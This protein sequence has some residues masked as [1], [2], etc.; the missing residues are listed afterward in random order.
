V[1][2]ERIWKRFFA[3]LRMTGSERLRMTAEVLFS[4]FETA[5]I[6]VIRICG[7]EFV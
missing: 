7:F 5:D 3:P 1:G 2:E 6:L 4:K